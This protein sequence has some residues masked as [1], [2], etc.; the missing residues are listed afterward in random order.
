V[1]S[2]T[3]SNG[4]AVTPVPGEGGEGGLDGIDVVTVGTG[5]VVGLPG[6]TTGEALGVV[7]GEALGVVTGEALGVVTGEA[8]GVVTGAVTGAVGFIMIVVGCEGWFIMAVGRAVG[9][10]IMAGMEGAVMDGFR[11][12]T[13]F[14]IMGTIVGASVHNGNLIVIILILRYLP[15]LLEPLPEPL[16]FLLLL[17]LLL[18]RII[19]LFIIIIIVI[20]MPLLGLAVRHKTRPG[21]PNIFWPSLWNPDAVVVALDGDVKAD[22]GFLVA[23]L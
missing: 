19:H 4:L 11:V 21:K 8:L 9:C 20:I 1:I 14:I 5:G 12:G 22:V 10:I 2:N 6:V 23:L 7:T 18:H 17:E 15:P 16:P 3:S 13:P